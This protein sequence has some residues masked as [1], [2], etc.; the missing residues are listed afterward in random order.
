MPITSKQE[1]L[2][3]LIDE[4]AKV[5]DEIEYLQKLEQQIKTEISSL[6]I[7]LDRTKAYNNKITV[8]RK[9]VKTHKFDTKKFRLEHPQLYLQY[10][11]EIEYEGIYVRRKKEKEELINA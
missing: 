11:T 10:L 9:K 5:R 2:E 8:F 3:Q 1:R 4:L 7:E 6:M